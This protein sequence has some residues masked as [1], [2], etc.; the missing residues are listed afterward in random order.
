MLS[1]IIISEIAC[2]DSPRLKIVSKIEL[3]SEIPR[4]PML[5]K[6]PMMTVGQPHQH[7]SGHVAGVCWKNLRQMKKSA[8]CGHLVR[9]G[10]FCQR[11]L[12]C[13]IGSGIFSCSLIICFSS[14]S[15]YIKEDAASIADGVGGW[16]R[17]L[18]SPLLCCDLRMLSGDGAGG[19]LCFEL[20]C[21]VASFS[22]TEAD[23]ILVCKYFHTQKNFA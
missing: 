13:R 11:R 21:L 15:Q 18:G 14:Y 6:R 3:T 12:L 5:L 19:S 9:V 1:W 2:A 16:A 10:L 23:N 20:V 7:W 4:V 17:I 22:E 8:H